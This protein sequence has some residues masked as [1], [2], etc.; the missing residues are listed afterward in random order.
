M[1]KEVGPKQNG[2]HYARPDQD[3]SLHP[4]P[5]TPRWCL[6]SNEK[7]QPKPIDTAELVRDNSFICHIDEECAGVNL[8]L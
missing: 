4:S 5:A 2:E 3:H 1:S 7:T 8:F 6:H